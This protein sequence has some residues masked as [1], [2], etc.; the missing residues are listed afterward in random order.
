MNP[1]AIIQLLTTL[2]PLLSGIAT[3]FPQ[4]ADIL[5]GLFGG[6]MP[7]ASGQA[8]VLLQEGLNALQAAGTVRFDGQ[9]GQSNSPLIVDGNFGGR[10]FAAVKA[11]QSAFGW[12]VTE[13]LASIE[14]NILAFVLSKL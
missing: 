13:P 8:V 1:L 5:G 12:T 10:T 7:T 3:S 4:L 9:A 2:A 14:M 6:A 11:A